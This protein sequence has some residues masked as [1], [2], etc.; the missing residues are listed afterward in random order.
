MAAPPIGLVIRR[1]RE[2]KRWTQRDLAEAV[3]VSR[4]SVDAWENNR[5]YPRNRIGALEEVLGVS[6][7]G[8]PAVAPDSIVATDEWERSVLD[9]RYLD[10][11][12]KRLLIESSRE[13]RLAYVAARRERR[14]AE[15]AEA[16]S[17]R[18][19]SAG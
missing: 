8:T 15:Q 12:T 13:A 10:A 14:E 19:T 5:T 4:A 1:A 18:G 16:R 2:R 6:L 9:D 11:E 3:G 17:D 7:N